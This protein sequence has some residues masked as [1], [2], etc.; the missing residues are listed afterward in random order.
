LPDGLLSPR[1]FLA[2][3]RNV[4][5]VPLVSPVTVAEAVV[6]APSENVDHDPSP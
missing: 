1:L 2:E 5:S 4:Y 3:T 6:E